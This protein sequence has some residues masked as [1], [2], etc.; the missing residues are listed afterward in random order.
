VVFPKL[1]LHLRF[2][3]YEFRAT[4]VIVS[5]IVNGKSQTDAW[6]KPLQHGN[7]FAEY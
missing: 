2:A 1:Q 5:S 3:I 4:L 7:R 6:I